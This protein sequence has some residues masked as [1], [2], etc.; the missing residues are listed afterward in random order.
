MAEATIK[1]VQLTWA[2]VLKKNQN[3]FK[4]TMKS[5]SPHNV[6]ASISLPLSKKKVAKIVRT[7]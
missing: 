3:G 4:C 1:R 6:L 7:S 5:Y 2:K